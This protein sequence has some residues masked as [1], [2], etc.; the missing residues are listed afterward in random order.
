MTEGSTDQWLADLYGPDPAAVSAQ[1]IAAS[2]AVAEP[3]APDGDWETAKPPAQSHKKA[4][5]VLGV[6]LAVAATGIVAALLRF[7]YPPPS[8]APH[9]PASVAASAAPVMAPTPAAQD[10]AIP[11]TAD[12]NCPTGSTSAQA[13][14]DSTSDSAWVCVRGGVDGQV[15]HLDLGKTYV[16][17]AVS[18]TPGWVAKTPGGKDE[19]LQHRVVG[20]LQY[21]FDDSDR[22]IITQD[23]GN[24]HGPVTVPLTNIVASRV[25]VIVLQTSRP[26]STPQPNGSAPAP[27]GGVIDSVLGAAG[28]PLPP[29]ATATNDPAPPGEPGSDPVDATFAMSGL[30]FFGHPPR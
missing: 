1:E 28:G 29:E 19:W 30:G 18:V 5:T 20:R 22:T 16:L 11:F 14:T 13:L 4:V 25:T 3:A 24:A 23:T 12:A 9:R 6:A 17:T 8:S 15:L 26:P 7:G 2:S 27:P 10:Q 21:I